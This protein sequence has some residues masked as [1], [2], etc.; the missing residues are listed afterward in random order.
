MHKY[1][2][3]I[4]Y[5]GS[6]YSGWQIQPNAPSIQEEIQKILFQVLAKPIQIC[7]SGRTDGGVHALGQVAH[8]SVED[9]VNIHKLFNALNGLLPWDIRIKNIK[10][11]DT[12]FHA[13]Y[14]A[15]GKIYHYHFWNDPVIDPM[16]FPYRLHL[17]NAFDVHRVQAA[18]ALFVGKKDFT[19]F[20][21]LRES[22][23]VLQNPIRHLKRLDLVL[24]EG[25]FR[26]EFEGD[27]FL[28]KMVRNIVGILLEVGQGRRQIET[29]EDLFLQKDRKSIGSPA[30]ARGLFLQQ[31]LYENN[32]LMC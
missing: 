17:R 18:L 12:D 27:G 22:H 4:S 9:P 25:G 16:F 1:I 24:Q 15:T 3:K 5:D 8:F 2:L 21:N 20:A 10:E 11:V 19:T 13:R 30:P 26:L 23:Q 31:V 7:G 28:Y 6:R 32:E 29:I 14:S